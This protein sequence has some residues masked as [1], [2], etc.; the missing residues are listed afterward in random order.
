M[1]VFDT[2]TIDNK[3]FLRPNDFKPAREYVYAG[4]I[5][6]CTGKT[7]ADLIGWKY[8]DMSLEWD[9]LPQSQ[10]EDL[11]DLD[12]TEV[13]FTFTDADGTTAS[14]TVIPLTHSL[15]AK[16]EV[17]DGIPAWKDVKTDLRFINVHHN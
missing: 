7:I 8:A 5:V 12:G 13:T 9:T 2:I 6:T 15:T 11:L 14:E 4:E 17:T 3:T 16:R 10:L 1:A